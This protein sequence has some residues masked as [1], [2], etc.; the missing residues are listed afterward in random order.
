MKYFFAVIGRSM[1][2]STSFPGI[3]IMPNQVFENGDKVQVTHCAGASEI[4]TKYKKGTVIA[5]ESLRRTL[6]YYSITTTP[7]PMTITGMTTPS[8][9]K[10]QWEQYKAKNP[11]W[12][13]YVNEMMDEATKTADPVRKGTVLSELLDQYP[14]PSIGTVGFHVDKQVWSRL[15]LAIKARRRNV[16][17]SGPTGSGKT[18]LVYQ[19]AKSLGLPISVLDMGS[20]HD[21]MSQMLGT[22]RLIGGPTGSVSKFEYASFV[23]QVQQPGIVLL[24]ELSRAPVTTL[25][26]L[27]PL[28]DDRR[29]LP[30][31]MAGESDKRKIPVHPECVFVATANLGA[32]YVGTSTLDEALKDRFVDFINLDYLSKEEEAELLITRAD[33]P[34]LDAMTVV[35]VADTIR[36]KYRDGTLSRPISTRS[37]LAVAEDIHDG[38]SAAQAMEFAFEPFFDGTGDLDSERA[39]VHNIILGRS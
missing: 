32:E 20:M 10:Q 12:E 19:L 24:D 36:R 35:E 13:N 16:L 1:N 21:P 3:Y 28:L 34:R 39:V 18:Q 7:Y 22:H 38:F 15:L 27:L 17:L 8:D 4:R 25:N 11:D 26:I 23:T 2:P 14:C 31:E 6:N 9:A 30:V 37:C 33:I 5:V 29:E